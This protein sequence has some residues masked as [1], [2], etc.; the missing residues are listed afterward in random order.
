MKTISVVDS[1]TLTC[2]PPLCLQ[3]MDL[4]VG[5]RYNEDICMIIN[6]ARYISRNRIWQI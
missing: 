2:L 5:G 6:E 1:A 4:G 3:V